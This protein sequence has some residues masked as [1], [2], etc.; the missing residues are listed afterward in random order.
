VPTDVVFPAPFKLRWIKTLERAPSTM[1]VQCRNGG[2]YKVDVDARAC[3][4]TIKETPPTLWTAVDAGHGE[5]LLAG[6]TDRLVRLSPVGMEPRSRKVTFAVEQ[7]PVGVPGGGYVK[8]MVR[9]ALTGR[10]VCGRTDGAVLVGDGRRFARLTEVSAAIRDLAVAPDRPDLF[11][12]SEDGGVAK[13]DLDSG[14]TRLAYRS[15]AGEPIWSLAYNPARDLLAFSER[16]GSLTILSGSDF[17]P[18]LTGIPSRRPKRMKWVDDDTLLF[19]KSTE[20]FRLDLRTG[21]AACLVETVGNTIEDFIWDVRRQ[22]LV[23]ASYTRYLILCDFHNGVVLDAAPD[24]IDYSKGLI[25]IEPVR[26]PDAYPLDFLSFGRSG[27]AHQF[28]I[29]D[30]KIFALG[31]IGGPDGAALDAGGER[32]PGDRGLGH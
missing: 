21:A 32:G 3:I 16:E 1:V 22:Y 8:R 7:A 17:R 13:I 9:Q 11:V 14:A 31:P 12:A 5:I 27:T 26:H 29:L 28:R 24:Q 2:L 6:E 18:V 23:L 4:A 25:A 15:P 20:L 19:G 30:E 10:L